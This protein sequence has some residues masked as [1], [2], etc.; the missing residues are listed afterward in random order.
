MKHPIL[1]KFIS[2]LINLSCFVVLSWINLVMNNW[3]QKGDAITN[4][5]WALP[6]AVVIGIGGG[7]LLRLVKA[8][9]SKKPNWLIFGLSVVVSFIWHIMVCYFWG[10][11]MSPFYQPFYLWVIGSFIQLIFLNKYIPQQTK[12]LILWKVVLQLIA[13]LY[14]LYMLMLAM[15]YVG[16]MV[17]NQLDVDDYNKSYLLK[18]C[19]DSTQQ[20]AYVDLN[21]DTL[22]P[23]MKYSKCFTDTFRRYAIVVTGDSEMIAIDRQENILYKVFSFDNGPDEPSDG[24]FRII[25]DNKIGFAESAY[26][27]VTIA[28]QYQC[29]Y[30]FKDGVAQV[31]IDCKTVLDGE[32]TVWQSDDWYTIDKQGNVITNKEVKNSKTDKINFNKYSY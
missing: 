31:S 28:P 15:I 21:R 25:V 27:T 16:M 22:I 13:F 26:G 9:S 5:F 23:S 29:A 2:V 17:D 32:H 20:C 18:V 6:I 12:K 30:P 3:Y 19:N 11:F 10:F 1:I 7:F 24:L 4:F 14:L 8:N